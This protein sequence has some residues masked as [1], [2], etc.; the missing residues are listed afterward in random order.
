M[1]NFRLKG[2]N[3]D[4]ETCDCCGKTG[5]ARVF[6]LAELGAGN[7]EIAEFAYGSDC[8]AKALGQTGKKAKLTV[9]ALNNYANAVAKITKLAAEHPKEKVS[10][11]ALRLHPHYVIKATK[12][13]LI[14][15]ANGMQNRIF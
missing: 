15:G 4:T 14:I 9:T 13:E 12:T 8:A 11:Y 6:W 2:V 1:R 5:L 7:E 3:S 10:D